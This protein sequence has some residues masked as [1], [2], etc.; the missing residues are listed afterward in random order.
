MPVLKTNK[1]GE[2]IDIAIASHHV[3]TT[4]D[5][6][7]LPLNLGTRLEDLEDRVDGMSV[8]ERID[9]AL[10]AKVGYT[11]PETHPVEMITGLSAVAVSGKYDDLL[12]KPTGLATEQYVQDEIAKINISG[13][14]SG[15]YVQP[16]WNIPEGEPGSILNKPTIPS[17]DGLVNESYV[18][19]VLSD[20]AKKSEIPDVSNFV[21]LEDVQGEIEKI[22]EVY[23][24]EYA[25]KEE[26][27]NLDDY[28]LKTYVQDE[29]AKIEVSGGS[30][31]TEVDIMTEHNIGPF[32]QNSNYG[33]A[34]LCGANFDT[35]D[36]GYI[37]PKFNFNVGDEFVV[38]WDDGVHPVTVQDASHM[39][40]GC[41]AVGHAEAFGIY[42][43]NEPFV[44]GWDS[45]GVTF[46]TL[47]ST[48]PYHKIRIYKKVAH[49]V[50]PIFTDSDEGKVL[51]VKDGELSWENGGSG[52][53]VGGASVQAD[54]NQVDDTQFSYIHN[55]P[56][57]EVF[58]TT[59]LVDGSYRYYYDVGN[60]WQPDVIPI[61]SDIHLVDGETYTITW[62]GDKYDSATGTFMGCM[63]IGN[64]G[65]LVDNPD[66]NI[67]FIIFED[68]DN[69]VGLGAGFLFMMVDDPDP[70]VTTEVMIDIKVEYEGVL[71]RQIDNKYLPILNR[72]DAYQKDVLPTTEYGPFTLDSNYDC[73][74]FVTSAEYSLTIGETYYVQWGDDVHECVAQDAD[75]VMPGYGVIGLGNCSAIEPSLSGN[76]ENFIIAMIPG[77]GITYLAITERGLSNSHTIRI[78]Q[79]VE[80][81]YVFKNEYQ[82]DW[83]QYDS[84]RP[85]FIKN[86]PFYSLPAGTPVVNNVVINC[87]SQDTETEYL[88]FTANKFTIAEN[89]KYDIVFDGV[90]YSNI[91]AENDG[92]NVFLGTVSDNVFFYITNMSGMLVLVSSQGEHTISI[93]TAEE[94]VQKIDPKYLP[95]SSGGSGLPDVTTDHNNNILQVVNGAWTVTSLENSTIASYIDEYIANALGGSY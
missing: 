10:E 23:L 2:W 91:A 82:P 34:Y 78:Y 15:E 69:T 3:H 54:W 7:G 5:I 87:N 92:T 25:L 43:N 83:E 94:F 35:D 71:T 93:L 41:F 30:A 20:Y 8:A 74:T 50:V 89:D 19:G 67:P 51:S 49:P 77:A 79:T 42:G 68:R 66:D 12:Y 18:Q 60:G 11:H 59:T 72:I 75:I 65:A 33:G 70:A 38:V 32:M 28:A 45:L 48:K 39:G 37:I 84:N 44:I 86:R 53:V 61:T 1:N 85:G 29:I 14:T 22:P 16:D 21:T 64:L 88:G 17:I 73:D 31:F 95:A 63:A 4:D 26:I 52:G 9:I 46:F 56:F 76:G 13:G 40:Q 27:P 47:E 36:N 81:N 80:E 6:D 55:K 90:L 57:G 62:N 24:S 58:A